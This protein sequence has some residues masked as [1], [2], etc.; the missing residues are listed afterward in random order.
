MDLNLDVWDS[1]PKELVLEVLQK[2]TFAQIGI[3]MISLPIFHD[4]GWLWN[5]L[6]ASLKFYY[7]SGLPWGSPRSW[8][9]ARFKVIVC[10][11]DPL[12]HNSRIL[13]TDS[14]GLEFAAWWPLTRR[15]QRINQSIS[16]SI[17]I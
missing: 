9:P 7:F 17:D 5:A 1:K 11:R 6:D 4:F 8:Q 13:G 14:R 10:P 2:T 3:I 16:F 12:M 15:G